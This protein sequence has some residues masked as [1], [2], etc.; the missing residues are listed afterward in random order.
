MSRPWW[1][2]FGV[3][4]A[5]TGAVTAVAAYVAWW[6]PPDWPSLPVS[7]SE[8]PGFGMA[9]LVL[10]ILLI[11]WLVTIVKTV[12]GT[13]WRD[14]YGGQHADEWRVSTLT[15]AVGLVAAAVYQW[16]ELKGAFSLGEPGASEAVFTAG[17][18]ATAA[19]FAVT[20]LAFRAGRRGLTGALGG[21][22][23]AVVTS[24]IV[25]IAV[26][27]LPVA[28]STTTKPVADGTT[29]KAAPQ[30]AVPA[31][32]GKI[33]WRWQ[34]PDG[35]PAYDV[36]VAGAGLVV[37]VTDGVVALDSVTGRERW[38]YR[39]P[40]SF[41]TGFRASPDGSTVT[42]RSAQRTVLLDAYTGVVLAEHWKGWVDENP[43]LN[44]TGVVTSSPGHPR[45][46]LWPGTLTGWQPTASEPAWHYS[47]PQGCLTGMNSDEHRFLTMA[48][49]V[50]AQII[51]CAPRIEQK[52]RDIDYWYGSSAFTIAVL[53]LDP[54]TG[55]EVWRREQKVSASPESVEI[56]RS[57]DAEALSVVWGEREGM[58]LE[59]AS[60][61][62]LARQRVTGS[63]STKGFLDVVNGM[64]DDDEW[65]SR[66]KPFG[67]GA[68]KRA[69]FSLAGLRRS[70]TSDIESAQLPLDDS[71]AVAYLSWDSRE[72]MK[73]TVLVTPWDTSETKRITVGLPERRLPREPV[74]LLPAPG[75][76]VVTQSASSDVVGLE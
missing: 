26:V 2:W 76:V 38:H 43:W 49:D 50:F 69:S 74:R 14:P 21:S 4:L 6:S 72:K 48:R 70:R 19:G 54:A 28:D 64:N 8:P 68:V 63:F 18:T 58:V 30:A 27:V 32:A 39:R 59:Q 29:T 41:A 7:S 23:V 52:S 66:W 9:A 75:A 10:G 46:K 25:L 56:H 35:A 67:M 40:G 20:A 47:P 34:T 37:R 3:G 57:E 17:L 73:A 53:G 11:W 62:V 24:A 22:A 45:A 60:G 44:S 15:C 55:A 12:R 16:F 1:G 51:I 65:T 33:A 71:L 13:D 5:L 61:K 31:S 42:I 36:A